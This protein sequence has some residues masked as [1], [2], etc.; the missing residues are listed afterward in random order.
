MGQARVGMTCND[1]TEGQIVHHVGKSYCTAN[2]RDSEG[3]GSNPAKPDNIACGV[4]LRWFL[5]LG[6]GYKGFPAYEVRYSCPQTV[7]TPLYLALQRL[8]VKVHF[9]AQKKH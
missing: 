9:E 5:L 8:G 7:F 1:P 6:F 3:S 4:A 2:E